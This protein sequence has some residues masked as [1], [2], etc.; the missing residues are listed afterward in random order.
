MRRKYY[1]SEISPENLTRFSCRPPHS[2]LQ[3]RPTGANRAGK[4]MVVKC[5]PLTR[6]LQLRL[7]THEDRDEIYRLRHAVY[8]E[9]L[10]QHGVNDEG[11]LIDAL[12]DVNIYFVASDGEDL[13]GCISVTPPG[14]HKY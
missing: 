1:E 11:R 14:A 10:G 2:P 7:A 3:S 9:E 6:K 8:A 4:A 5:P 12:D 13:A